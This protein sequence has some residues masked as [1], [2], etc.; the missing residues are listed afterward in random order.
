MAYPSSFPYTALG[1]TRVRWVGG[2]VHHFGVE[3]INFQAICGGLAIKLSSSQSHM[4]S[5]AQRLTWICKWLKNRSSQSYRYGNMS[6]SLIIIIIRK[7]SFWEGR[8]SLPLRHWLLLFN[9]PTTNPWNCPWNWCSRS[10]Y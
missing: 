6:P 9:G 4:H 5:R 1:E 3:F 8:S 10:F 2:I 7:T